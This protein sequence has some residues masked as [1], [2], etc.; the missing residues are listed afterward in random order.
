M[1]AQQIVKLAKDIRQNWNTSDPYEI[2]RKFGIIVSDRDVDVKGFKA[3]I[4]KTEGYPAI[5]AIN[6][7]YTERSRK[8]LC[9]H[10]LGHALLHWDS[11]NHFSVTEKNLTTSVEYEADLF[12]LALLLDESQLTIPLD[13]MSSSMIRYIM[14]YNI[15]RRKDITKSY[16]P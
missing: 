11:I 13:K 15:H 6:N 4:L 12:A 16:H 8:V 1:R 2:A 14:N 7:A 5:I 9:A 3:H 10:E